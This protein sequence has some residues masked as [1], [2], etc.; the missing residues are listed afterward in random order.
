MFE[1]HTIVAA[2]PT[3]QRFRGYSVFADGTV[4]TAEAASDRA[5]TRLAHEACKAGERP[6]PEH[7]TAASVAMDQLDHVLELHAPIGKASEDS[8]RLLLQRML[9]REI[10]S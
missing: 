10:D 1:Q 7:V 3:A 5:Y 9:L 6:W 2:S 4:L 8:A